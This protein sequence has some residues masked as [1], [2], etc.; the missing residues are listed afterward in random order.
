[1][2]FGLGVC[3]GSGKSDSLIPVDGFLL[4]DGQRAG[5]C[6]VKTPWDELHKRHLNMTTKR[7]A[8][9][10][11]ADRRLP[12]TVK[13]KPSP[14]VDVL[15]RVHTASWRNQTDDT[16]MVAWINAQTGRLPAGHVRSRKFHEVMVRHQAQGP[17]EE[18]SP[19]FD[20]IVE[21]SFVG[22]NATDD[23]QTQE[24][25]RNTLQ[26]MQKQGQ[27]NTSTCTSANTWMLGTGG[28]RQTEGWGEFELKPHR[29]R[30]DKHIP[31]YVTT[32]LAAV[33]SFAY[34]STHSCGALLEL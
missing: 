22:V 6:K 24:R 31:N 7:N 29:I 28:N 19:T 20:V 18:E 17:P 14:T 4:A 32:F 26:T 11:T 27:N 3:L 2:Y 33:S 1:L 10:L 23:H 30:D 25:V 34:T 15:V 5:E 12:G 8:A 9:C 16:P 21:C 13:V